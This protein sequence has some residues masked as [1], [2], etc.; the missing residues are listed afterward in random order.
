MKKMGM[1][2]LSIGG[3]LPAAIMQL[4]EMAQLFWWVYKKIKHGEPLT[5]L[6]RFFKYK[7]TDRNAVTKLRDDVLSN[8]QEVGELGGNVPTP[9]LIGGPS[10]TKPPEPAIEPPEPEPSQAPQAPQAPAPQAPAPQAPAPQGGDAEFLPG[11]V[12]A[13]VEVPDKVPDPDNPE[14]LTPEQEEQLKK[15]LGK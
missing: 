8:E 5:D 3:G 7:L 4:Y 2:G 10:A 13:S 15:L 11:K 12:G 6:D 14:G 1:E 9:S